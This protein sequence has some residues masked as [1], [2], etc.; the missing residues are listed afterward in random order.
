MTLYNYIVVQCPVYCII[1][2]LMIT[3]P[4]INS[5]HQLINW[6]DHLKRA[7]SAPDCDL[8]KDL[9]WMLKYCMLEL[10]W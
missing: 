4:R 6:P 9:V 8:A 2:L 10:D 5:S 7:S 3:L 1:F